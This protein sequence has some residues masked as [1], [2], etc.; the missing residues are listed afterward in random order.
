MLYSTCVIIS[1]DFTCTRVYIHIYIYIYYTKKKMFVLQASSHLYNIY[2][3]NYH[4]T[5]IHLLHL[6]LE[7]VV[8]LHDQLC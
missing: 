3:F 8:V 7:P 2:T 5:N 1:Y 4:M 6:V